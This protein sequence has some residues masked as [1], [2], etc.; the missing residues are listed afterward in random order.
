M[1]AH[2]IADGK[3]FYGNHENIFLG[4]IFAVA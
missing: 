2:P 3:L 4:E 1:Q